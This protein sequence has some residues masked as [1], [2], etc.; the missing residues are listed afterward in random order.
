MNVPSSQRCVNLDWLEVTSRDGL[1]FTLDVMASL[2]EDGE[3]RLPVFNYKGITARDADGNLLTVSDGINC[4][5]IVTV[6]AGFDGQVSVSFECISKI[7][8][9]P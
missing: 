2:E 9:S 1:S 6:P 5:A 7:S 3:I 4:R 8:F